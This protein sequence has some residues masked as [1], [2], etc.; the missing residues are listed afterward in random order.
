MDV[1]DLPALN[2]LLNL[3][4]AVLVLAGIWFIRRKD[5]RRHRAM[6]LAAV[7]ASSLFLVSYLYYHYQ[8]GSVPYRG[9]GWVR[10][11]YFAVLLSHTVLA[12][13]IVPLVL[14]TVYLAVAGRIDRHRRI[15]RWTF[16][17]WIYVSGTG[18]LVY[19]MLYQF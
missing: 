16:P 7:G 14:G 18:V 10:T 1:A 9:E 3:T 5:V 17:I 13:I 2:A 6:M 11:L 12:A 4:S 8:V 19:L 15:A